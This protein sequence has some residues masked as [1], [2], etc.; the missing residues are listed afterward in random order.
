LIF[1]FLKIKGQKKPYP[2]SRLFRK[3]TVVRTQVLQGMP[4]SGP[5][6]FRQKGFS[7]YGLF[8]AELR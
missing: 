7:E 3:T 5:S 8:S 4:G 6:F 1:L 2:D